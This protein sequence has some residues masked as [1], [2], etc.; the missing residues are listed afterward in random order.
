MASSW[1]QVGPKLAQVGLKLVL[2]TLEFRNLHDHWLLRPLNFCHF[3]FVSFCW[4]QVGSKLAH[5]WHRSFQLIQ[6]L[7]AQVGP[8]WLQVEGPDGIQSDPEDANAGKQLLLNK[9]IIILAE[10]N[11]LL[12]FWKKCSSSSK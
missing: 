9:F 11:L 7:L 3:C 8:S 10:I 4:L 12:M 2:N 1:L 5:V 6:F